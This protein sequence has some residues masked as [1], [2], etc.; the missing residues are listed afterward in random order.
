[1]VNL[2][3]SQPGKVRNA[4]P[5]WLGIYP[6]DWGTDTGLA[7]LWLPWDSH[8]RSKGGLRRRRTRL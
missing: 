8:Y 7:I 1:M 5:T 6:L 3:R 2:C 4:Y